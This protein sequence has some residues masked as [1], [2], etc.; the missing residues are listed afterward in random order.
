MTNNNNINSN[1]NE[2]KKTKQLFDSLG[3]KHFPSKDQQTAK[4]YAEIMSVCK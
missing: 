3:I 1:V 2:Y 4:Q